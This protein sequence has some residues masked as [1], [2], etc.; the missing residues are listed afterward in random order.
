MLG[1]FAAGIANLAWV[2]PLTLL[3]VFEKAGKGGN[4]VVV[5]LGVGLPALGA[6]VLARP[7][8]FPA[9]FAG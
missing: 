7:T 2:A 3:L 1:T 6:L 9:P 8:W 5:P 4:R